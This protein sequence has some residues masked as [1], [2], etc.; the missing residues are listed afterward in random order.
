[1][2]SPEPLRGRLATASHC[3]PDLTPP[4]L[5][6]ICLH[7]VPELG[8]LP[9]RCAAR[10]RT[11]AAVAAGARLQ[12]GPPDDLLRCGAGW[13]PRGAAVGAEERLRLG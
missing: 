4:R 12:V 3:L 2:G 13:A 6:T 7:Q 11:G 10:Q 9:G 8:Y 1:M 5:N